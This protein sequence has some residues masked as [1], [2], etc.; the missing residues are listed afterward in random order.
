MLLE[1]KLSFI[2]SELMIKQESLS[3]H[4]SGI[5]ASLFVYTRISNEQSQLRRGKKVTLAVIY[6]MMSCF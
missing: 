4:F 2:S 6:L 3:W 5:S 1:T